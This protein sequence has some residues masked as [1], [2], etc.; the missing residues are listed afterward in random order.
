[1]EYMAYSIRVLK[2]A[3]ADSLHWTKK[4]RGPGCGRSAALV[5][6]SALC[7]CWW[8]A[9]PTAFNGVRTYARMPDCES[10]RSEKKR[11]CRRSLDEESQGAVPLEEPGQS[12]RP[13]LVVR[14]GGYLGGSVMRQVAALRCE[15]AGEGVFEE[16][17]RNLFGN[18]LFQGQDASYVVASGRAQTSDPPLEPSPLSAL[19]VPLRNLSAKATALIEPS[20]QSESVVA[21]S[22]LGRLAI[23]G[24]VV[25]RNDFLITSV[26]VRK[27]WRR[28]GIGTRLVRELLH[29]LPRRGLDR[30]GQAF[31]AWAFTDSDD[32]AAFLKSAGARPQGSLLQVLFSNPPV[33]LA[34]LISAFA[35]AQLL[36]GAQIYKFEALGN[37]TEYSPDG[38]LGKN[39]V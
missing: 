23:G 33:G 39:Q 24:F 25:L 18:I 4:P 12:W 14:D 8:F 11:A 13:R 36:G 9:A 2:L 5:G 30:A 7:F 10:L 22:Q 17:M 3:R 38:R 15:V 37:V 31:H 19:L 1:M 27:Q 28:R 32:G 26:Q 34:L 16:V 35:P 29:R 20:L 21:F 6:A